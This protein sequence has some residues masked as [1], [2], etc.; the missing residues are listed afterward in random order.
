MRA[1]FAEGV[2]AVWPVSVSFR[3]TVRFDSKPQLP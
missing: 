1:L 2:K 3:D